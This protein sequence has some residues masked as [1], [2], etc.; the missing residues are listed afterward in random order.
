VRLLLVFVN[1]ALILLL[2]YLSWWLWFGGSFFSEVV[3]ISREDPSEYV[4][5]NQRLPTLPAS[6]YE[7]VKMLGCVPATSA[8]TPTEEKA[9]TPIRTAV[10]GVIHQFLG[11]LYDRTDKDQSGIF[12]VARR[13]DGRYTRLVGVFFKVGDLVVEKP[14]IWLAAVEEKVPNLRYDFVFRD[15]KGKTAVIPLS[16]E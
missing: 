13:Q 9:P 2:G 5:K 16:L 11:V 14:K 4:P 12:V 1:L 6:F 15:E 8:P 3:N 7:A 10:L